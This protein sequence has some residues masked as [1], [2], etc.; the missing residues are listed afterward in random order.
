MNYLKVAYRFFKKAGILG[1]GKKKNILG[2]NPLLIS[3][4]FIVLT[5]LL[6]NAARKLVKTALNDG[7]MRQLLLEFIATAELCATC[8]ELI[9]VA[10]NFGV[11]VYALYLFLL[12]IWWG[13]TWENASACP[14]NIME[15]V[16]EGTQKIT[17]ATLLILS[18]VLGGLV[19]FRY[20]QIL[21]SL[22]LTE[23]HRGR[24]DEEC[25]A[26]L[27]VP[28]LFGA[29]VEGIATC[30]CRLTSKFLGDTEA[31]FASTVDSFF[32]TM[33]VVAAFNFSGGYFNPALATSLKFGCE[34]NTAVEHMIVYWVGAS[35]GSLLSV[36]IYSSKPMK[37]LVCRLKPK[38]E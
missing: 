21:W 3:T 10:D 38:Q 22:E 24:A 28:M 35:V 36:F 19:I 27:Q 11:W 23:N 9:I 6:A 29:M 2:M 30:L 7:L 26:D 12:T 33:M 34:G 16:A 37:N 15:E 25:T 31:R 5:A 13:K 8:F 32:A 20:I 18:Q 4:L 17:T 1:Y 14:Y